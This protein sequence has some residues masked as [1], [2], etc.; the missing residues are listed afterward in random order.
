M[1]RFL[2]FSVSILCLSIAVLIG[3]YVGSQRVEAQAPAEVQYFYAHE[4]SGNYIMAILPNGD[5][6]HNA[7]SGGSPFTEESNY[8]GNFWTGVVATEQSSW[9]NIKDL[10]K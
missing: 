3:F 2:M 7:H 1:K 5:V 10:K 8:I 4:A 6:Y 9:G